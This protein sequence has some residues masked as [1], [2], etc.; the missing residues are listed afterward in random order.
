L[1]NK[2]P[3]KAENYNRLFL[4]KNNGEY[5]WAKEYRLPEVGHSFDFMTTPYSFTP[6]YGCGMTP[7]LEMVEAYEYCDGQTGELHIS[8]GSAPIKYAH[9]L[10]LFAGKDPR[11]FASIYLPMSNFKDGIVEI[12]RGV[13]READNSFLAADNLEKKTSLADDTQITIGG[14]DG[15]MLSKDP[16]K[17]GFYQKKFYDESRIDFSEGKS[18]QTWPVFRL[19]EMYLNKAEAEMELG[20]RDKAVEALNLIRERAGIK[21]LTADEISLQRIRNERRIELAFEGHRFWDLRRWRIAAQS[22]APGSGVLAPL[23]PT[24]LWPWV[25]YEDG[26]Y[27]FTKVSGLVNVQKP[28]KIFFQ[29]HY[30][31]KFLPEEMN[32]NRKLIQNPGY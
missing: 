25:V 31:L 21:T 26:S 20:N 9:P 8:N 5:I 19:T 18:D 28:D 2:Y 4:D 3:D 27:I 14:K 12:R 16:T 24:A 17:T 10:D 1:Y 13:Y 11:L 23:T 30:Y 29:R 6:G 32:S 7:T 15:V 22:D